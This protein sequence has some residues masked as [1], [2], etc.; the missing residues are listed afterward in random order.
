MDA[1]SLIVDTSP[2]DA[3]LGAL[4]AGLT[5]HSLK[6][7]E[8]RGF[9]PLAVFARREDGHLRGGVSGLCNWNWLQ[10]NLLW[11]DPAE[12]SQGL[13]TSLLRRIEKEAYQRGCRRAHLNTFGFQARPFYEG[14]GYRVFAELNDYPPGF[15]R[16]FLEKT[17]GDD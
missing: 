9:R 17:L 1:D 13:G 6:F 8:Q 5:E 2:S 3:D 11:V 7:I 16:S 15:T 10:I 4:G 12:R 14:H